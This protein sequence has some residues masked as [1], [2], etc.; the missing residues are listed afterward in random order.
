[1][2]GPFYLFSYALFRSFYASLSGLFF[3]PYLT[4]TATPKA[5]LLSFFLLPSPSLPPSL[6]QYRFSLL[7]FHT[8]FSISLLSLLSF[9]TFSD[10]LSLSPPHLSEMRLTRLKNQYKHITN[11]MK[12]KNATQTDPFLGPSK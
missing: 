2:A 12:P 7:P 8:P 9:L 10:S 1:M 3:W 5:F 11:R 6:S 4:R